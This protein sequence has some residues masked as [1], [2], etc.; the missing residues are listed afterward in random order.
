MDN[1]QKIV[2]LV[3]NDLSTDQR[4]RKMCNSLIKLGYSIEL[5]GRKFPDSKPLNRP[6]KTKRFRLWFNKGALF[7]ANLNIRLFFYLLFSKYD[8]IQAND[9]DTLLPAYLISKLRSKPLVYDTHEIFTEVPEIQGRWVKKVWV[10]LEN[11]LFP[12]IKYLI[13]VN[14][15]IADFYKQKFNRDDIMVI[16]NIPEKQSILKTKSR[17]DLNLPSDR[18][19]LIVQGA[20]INVDRGIEE[21]V[22]S[23]KH[24]DQILLLIVGGGDAIPR[25]KEM[26]SKDNLS[27]KVMFIQR[28]PYDQMMQYT[29][30]SDL[31]ISVDKPTSLNYE[32]SLPN[33]IFDYI[34]AEI[35]LLV[36]NLIEVTGI[37]ENYEIGII[38]NTVEPLEIARAVEGFKEN[39]DLKM[40]MKENLKKA[41]DAVAWENDAK[42]LEN[43]Y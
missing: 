36:S 27:D 42:V 26:V 30:N 17:T 8:R 24:L 4:V 6:Y 25:L 12:K 28:L 23:L 3:S 13:T 2:V 21:V 11:N 32:F 33:K 19:I 15:T 39:V 18:F 41:S 9:L 10:S 7:Y 29:M 35:P 34:R 40:R 5:I 16:R 43:I 1:Q 22:L 38:I 14:Q 31:G 37:V 20:G